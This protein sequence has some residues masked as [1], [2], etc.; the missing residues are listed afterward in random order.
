MLTLKPSP[1]MVLE[2][3]ELSIDFWTLTIQRPTQFL[4]YLPGEEKDHT[5]TLLEEDKLLSK[6][7]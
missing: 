2:S 4:L 7:D 1:E 3:C 6:A 5:C